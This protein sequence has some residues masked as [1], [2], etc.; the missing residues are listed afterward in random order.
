MTGEALAGAKGAAPAAWRG[1]GGSVALVAF[2]DAGVGTTTVPRKGE[3]RSVM[4]VAR[5][6]ADPR[7]GSRPRVAPLVRLRRLYRM[8]RRGALG[9]QAVDNVGVVDG[10]AIP[11]WGAGPLGLGPCWYRLDLRAPGGDDV[12]LRIAK[13]DAAV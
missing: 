13:L 1:G 2:E 10:A 6:G 7:L 12:T 3:R 9:L 4:R 8:R 5:S 11:A